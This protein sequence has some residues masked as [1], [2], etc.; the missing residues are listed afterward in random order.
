MLTDA[1]TRSIARKFTL[2]MLVLKVRC[3]HSGWAN[4]LLS[5]IR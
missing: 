5:R 2:A 4:D 1:L 3:Y